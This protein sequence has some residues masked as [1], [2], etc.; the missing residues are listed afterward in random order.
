MVFHAR[1]TKLKQPGSSYGCKRG[2][3]GEGAKCPHPGGGGARRCVARLAST[4]YTDLL[5]GRAWNEGNGN[6]CIS[7]LPKI[8]GGYM[9]SQTK[10]GVWWSDGSKDSE[11]SRKI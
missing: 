3:S 5:R 10:N 1:R 8:E 6:I 11:T 2:E 4:E 7:T 9:A